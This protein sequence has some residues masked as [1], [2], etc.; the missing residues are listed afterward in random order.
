[1]IKYTKRILSLL[2][3]A[4]PFLV[5]PNTQAG[6]LGGGSTSWSS[7]P[8]SSYTSWWSYEA[9][10]FT[11]ANTPL[12]NADGNPILDEN[13][14]Q[15]IIPAATFDMTEPDE[16]TEESCG[17]TNN[18]TKYVCK[19]VGEGSV[20]FKGTLKV[21]HGP[22]PDVGE[23]WADY[24]MKWPKVKITIYREIVD[25]SPSTCYGDEEN[26]CNYLKESRTFEAVLHN[27]INTDKLVDGYK[28]IRTDLPLS[29]VYEA[30]YEGS[31]LVEDKYLCYSKI[32][33]GTQPFDPFE[34]F[35]PP[36]TT[37]SGATI[38]D[39]TKNDHC[40]GFYWDEACLAFPPASLGIQLNGQDFDLKED[41]DGYFRSCEGRSVAL[42]TCAYSEIKDLSNLEN[43]VLYPNRTNPE[44]GVFDCNDTNDEGEYLTFRLIDAAAGDR[45][46]P[47][48]AF[49]CIGTEVSD[50][51]KLSAYSGSDEK[52]I[53]TPCD[54]SQGFIQLPFTWSD[55]SIAFTSSEG[56]NAV[57]NDLNIVS[58]VGSFGTLLVESPD[59]TDSDWDFSNVNM[60]NVSAIYGL[61]LDDT[62]TGTAG[63]DVILG[64]N[65]ND[66][67][68]GFEGNDCIDGEQND[69][70]LWG[71]SHAENIDENGADTGKIAVEPG[72]DVF[73]LNAKLGKDTIN[74]FSLTDDWIVNTSNTTVTENNI[75][76]SNATT[77]TVYLK[78]QNY[79]NVLHDGTLTAT[80]LITRVVNSPNSIS[81]Q[82]CEGHPLYVQP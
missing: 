19:Y 60:S 7:Y 57:I 45:L 31:T 75:D 52:L 54:P 40:V 18:D 8:T 48:P 35:S 55:S 29:G 6:T 9:V 23:A 65:G 61:E 70:F 30:C 20:L 59:K 10:T 37:A 47:A 3:T 62:I 82:Q 42:N 44:P 72:A 66:S 21:T 17:Y 39:P 32:G 28:K 73:V 12:T 69:D 81:L 63:S 49:V 78:G 14:N 27:G 68:F 67:L 5:A 74:D 76:C 77:C 50:W 24:Q 64:G 51:L 1:M 11:R 46:E 2:F 22:F 4:I 79:V 80:Q 16:F 13:N 34:I 38:C 56:D 25:P 36:T 58:I 33:Y 26:P 43:P 53:I 71:D 41:A 15:I